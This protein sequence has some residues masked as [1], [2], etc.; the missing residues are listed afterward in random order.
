MEGTEERGGAQVGWVGNSLRCHDGGGCGGGGGGGGGDDAQRDG[1][2]LKG[3]D[4]Y[5][6]QLAV[7]RGATST[8]REAK[9]KES[10]VRGPKRP[11]LKVDWGG[12]RVLSES[13]QIQLP[14]SHSQTGR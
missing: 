1:D 8:P 4:T 2:I 5:F 9:E 7:L 11:L 6:Q 3:K 13:H 14:D 10:E 12:W